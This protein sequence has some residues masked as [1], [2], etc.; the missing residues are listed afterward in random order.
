MTTLHDKQSLSTLL[1]D[2]EEKAKKATPARH[3]YQISAEN[4]CR[5]CA[6]DYAQIAI[7]T[8]GLDADGVYRGNKVTWATPQDVEYIDAACSPDT[9]LTLITAL[10]ELQARNEF[11]EDVFNN[12][13]EFIERAINDKIALREAE[14]VI[15][16]YEDEWNYDAEPTEKL[17]DDCGGKARMWLTKHA[18]KVATKDAKGEKG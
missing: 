11:L 9:V 17:L 5:C 10:G 15:E 7:T 4:R 16:Y 1:N 2:L 12:Q 8:D 14:K 18:P 3:L 6:C 13:K